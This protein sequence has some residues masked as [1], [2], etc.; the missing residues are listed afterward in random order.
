MQY[1]QQE[2]AKLNSKNK[3]KIENLH[4]GRPWLADY[5]H[6]NYEAA[7]RATEV[8]HHSIRTTFRPSRLALVWPVAASLDLKPSHLTGLRSLCPFIKPISCFE[9]NLTTCTLPLGRI[10]QEPGLHPRR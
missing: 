7:K 4:D 3:L 1:V 10:P 9:L 6:W 2:F 8:S 5:K